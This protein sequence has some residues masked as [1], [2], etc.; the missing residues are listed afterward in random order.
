MKKITRE[1]AVAISVCTGIVAVFV[2]AFTCVPTAHQRFLDDLIE[3]G[4]SLCFTTLCFSAAVAIGCV[5]YATLRLVERDAIRTRLQLLAN[6]LSMRT[7][8]KYAATVYRCLQ[9][10][11]YDTL[12]QN[13][14]TLQLPLG[15]DAS[16]LVPR[17][18]ATQF[19]SGCLFYRFELVMPQ[20]PDMDITTM[21]QII[22]THV[23]A[24][25]MNYGIA[26]LSA[27]FKHPT[28]GTIPSVYIDR[29]RYDEETHL[30]QIEM[31]YISTPSSAEYACTAMKRDTHKIE[32]ERAVFDDE[33]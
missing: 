32:P 26:G 19:R 12:R 24:E 10:F 27:W 11:L 18:Y 7:Q 3:L 2:I 13:S 25:L 20:A 9:L 23:T 31:L 15:Q 33:L 21:R 22:Q 17:G 4:V 1:K 5:A 8:Q 30:L 28:Y 29:M 16:C 6:W 14:S